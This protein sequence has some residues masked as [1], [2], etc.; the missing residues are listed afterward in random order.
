MPP[1]TCVGIEEYAP[2]CFTA[3]TAR[4]KSEF[5]VLLSRDLGIRIRLGELAYTLL[6]RRV[7]VYLSLS[8]IVGWIGGL[9]EGA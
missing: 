3:L 4:S 5:A 7:M 1:T 6:N 8:L 2:L 9:V